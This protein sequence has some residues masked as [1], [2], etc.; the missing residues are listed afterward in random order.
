MKTIDTF[1]LN[2][3]LKYFALKTLKHLIFLY[4]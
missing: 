1:I 4:Y 3:K 2:D